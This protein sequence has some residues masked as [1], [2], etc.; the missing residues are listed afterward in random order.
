[1]CCGAISHLIVCQAH[2]E[3]PGGQDKHCPGGHCL[4]PAKQVRLLGDGAH[5]TST[6]RPPLLAKGRRPFKFVGDVK[7]KRCGL[8][9]QGGK[10]EVCSRAPRVPELLPQPILLQ[11]K[12]GGASLQKPKNPSIR[13]RCKKQ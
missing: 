3:R 4:P 12:G 11:I 9:G 1:M 8:P 2:S 13:G 5:G 7:W 6:D 10:R